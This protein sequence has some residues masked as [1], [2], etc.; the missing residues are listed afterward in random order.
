MP[1]T[2][3]VACDTKLSPDNACPDTD[4]AFENAL[5]ICFH[6]GYGMFVDNLAATLPNN[7]EDRWLRDEDGEY[8]TVESD[9]WEGAVDPIDNPD[10]K[11]TFN[12]P[13]VLFP[14]ADY[15][16]VICHECAHKLC[17]TI[18]WIHK[19]LNPHGSHAHKQEYHEA[20]PDHDG[21]D[22]EPRV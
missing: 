5:W 16:A 8:L 6:G 4:Y 20:H 17:D 22:Y 19:L 9:R 3:C 7:T 11:P 15:E 1:D 14:P 12:E 18:P 21:W 2:Y 13:H 10:Y